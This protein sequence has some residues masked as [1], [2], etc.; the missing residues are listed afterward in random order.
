VSEALRFSFTIRWREELVCASAAGAFALDMPGH[1]E[2]LVPSAAAAA[3]AGRMPAWARD[4]R[5]S[6][7]EQLAAWC[8][9]G[10]HRLTEDAQAPVYEA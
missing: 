3:W 8:R 10:G 6:F 9:G 4:H 2:V 7:L 5:G 1:T